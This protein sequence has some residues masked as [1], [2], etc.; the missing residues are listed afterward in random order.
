MQVPKKEIRDRIE[1]AA[2]EDFLKR[3]FSNASMR[4]IAK[5][6]QVSTSNLY[7]YF[8]SKE[9]LFYSITSPT[10][11][12]IN[13]LL[14][15]FIE[16][17]RK[18]GED[19]F[20]SQITQLMGKPIGKVIKNHRV[21]FLLIMDKSHG[22]KYENFKNDLINVLEEHFLEHIQPNTNKKNQ[23][24][25]D[26]FV[27]HIVATNLLEGFL[28]ISRHYKDDEWIDNNIN[29]LMNYHINGISTFI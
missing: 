17:E 24:L 16:T 13:D 28:E 2:R 29:A 11:R 3:G 8:K 20:F 5:K 4:S 1:A 22:T 14:Q 21:E 6:A 27:L 19:Q 10:I 9:E 7:N 25:R 18:L 26:T 12:K 15:Q 23:K